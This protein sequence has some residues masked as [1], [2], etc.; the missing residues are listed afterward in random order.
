MNINRE[1]SFYKKIVCEECGHA[2][3]QKFELDVRDEYYAVGNPDSECVEC[4]AWVEME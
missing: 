1:T 4:G 2:W 3:L